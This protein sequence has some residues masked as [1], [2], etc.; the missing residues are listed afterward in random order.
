MQVLKDGKYWEL[1][2]T[3]IPGVFSPFCHW[4]FMQVLKDGKN[5]ELLPTKLEASRFAHCAATFR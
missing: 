1:L 5:W 2:P 4:N 3:K